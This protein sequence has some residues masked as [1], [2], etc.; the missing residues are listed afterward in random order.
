MPIGEAVAIEL[1]DVPEAEFPVG[2]GRVRGL[3]LHKLIEEILSGEVEETLLALA[4][5]ADTLMLQLVVDDNGRA[6]LPEKTE[7]A[8]TA[9]RALQLPGIA[10]LRPVLVPEL[11]LFGL[12]ETDNAQTA[13]SG[14][15]DAIAFDG[16]RASVILDWK[17]DVAPTAEDIRLHT[18]QLRHYIAAAGAQRGAL[19]YLTPGTVHWIES[20]PGGGSS[21]AAA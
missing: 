17:S 4:A 21:P 14:R 9:L 16:A 19:V 5:R 7:I 3:V 20:K 12:T 18:G 11:T 2:A 1:Y 10:E 8:A 6:A 15:A 13:L